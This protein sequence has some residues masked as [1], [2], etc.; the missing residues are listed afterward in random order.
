MHGAAHVIKCAHNPR[1]TLELDL[2]DKWNSDLET[3]SSYLSDLAISMNLYD[4]MQHPLSKTILQNVDLQY[5]M[6]YN[7]LLPPQANI[8]S[9]F[10]SQTFRGTVNGAMPRQSI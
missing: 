5:G 7:G 1:G 2:A 4:Y 8:F 10:S 3:A 9:Y 6:Q